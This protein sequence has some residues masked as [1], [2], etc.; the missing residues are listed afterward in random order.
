MHVRDT[1]ESIYVYGRSEVDIH[2]CGLVG[3]GGE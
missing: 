1:C 3:G 2:S